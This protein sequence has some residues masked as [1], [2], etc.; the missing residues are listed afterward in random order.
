MQEILPDQPTFQ[1]APQ[2]YCLDLFDS[3]PWD[4]YFPLVHRDK[5]MYILNQQVSKVAIVRL[6]NAYLAPCACIVCLHVI[7]VN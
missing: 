2:K 1:I 6:K 7:K 4:Q 5:A 3:G